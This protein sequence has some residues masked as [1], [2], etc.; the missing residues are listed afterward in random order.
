MEEM[1]VKNK[2]RIKKEIDEEIEKHK[3]GINSTK[4]LDIQRLTKSNYQRSLIEN[5]KF[6]KRNITMHDVKTMQ[7]YVELLLD[8]VHYIGLVVSEFIINKKLKYSEQTEY[9]NH[10]M[11]EI[12]FIRVRVSSWID[13]LSEIHT[14]KY[15]FAFV[16]VD[17]CKSFLKDFEKVTYIV[18]YEIPNIVKMLKV[19]VKL[20]REC[21]EIIVDVIVRSSNII[22]LLGDCIEKFLNRKI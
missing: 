17:I 19:N 14:G 10:V 4:K 2:I 7:K 11:E 16:K 6:K 3:E 12:I 21:E 9:A 5:K 13:Y 15:P 20:K 18:D 22:H 1:N 8:E